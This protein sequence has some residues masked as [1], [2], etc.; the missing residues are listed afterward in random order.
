MLTT[1]GMA[2]AAASAR[3]LCPTPLLTFSPESQLYGP[4]L[5]RKISHRLSLACSLPN[6]LQ[7]F[8]TDYLWPALFPTASKICHRLSL[9]CP[10]TDSLQKLPPA[11]SGLLSAQSLAKIITNF[12]WPALSP[13][14]CGWLGFREA[15]FWKQALEPMANA[16]RNFVLVWRGD[17]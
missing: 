3:K 4:T 14:A 5:F 9:V 6:S 1:A 12:L 15:I 11:F 13:S 2:L 8:A 17:W 16:N 7:K 10:I